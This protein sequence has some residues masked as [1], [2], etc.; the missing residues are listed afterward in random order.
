ML[1]I[2]LIEKNLG[3]KAKKK[4]LPLQKGD[5]ISTHSSSKLLK[6]DFGYVPKTGVEHGVKKLI[7][8]YLSYYK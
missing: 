6:K 8:W 7:N 1:Y 5:V 2:K 3:I 4:Y